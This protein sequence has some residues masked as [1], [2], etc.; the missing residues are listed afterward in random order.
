MTKNKNY[1]TVGKPLFL[2]YTCTNCQQMDCSTIPKKTKHKIPF[3]IV[4]DCG[5]Y[6][7]FHSAWI[8]EP[9]TTAE[10][11]VATFAN[12]KKILKEFNK[13]GK[14]INVSDKLDPE[15]TIDPAEN[16]TIDIAPGPDGEI[17]PM[18]LEPKKKR[19]K[20]PTEAKQVCPI[21][22]NE[23]IIKDID[24]YIERMNEAWEIVKKALPEAYAKQAE[25]EIYKRNHPDK[26]RQHIKEKGYFTAF[27]QPCMSKLSW[28]KQL[29]T[30]V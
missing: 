10:V 22:G 11:L 26:I 16:P 28:S 7:M 20:P 25:S 27:C 13:D 4:C 3:F 12:D 21:C 29:G 2:V 23:F 24:L 9:Y 15:G 6:K 1:N 5:G 19:D 8:V 30:G 17:D 14:F 18:I